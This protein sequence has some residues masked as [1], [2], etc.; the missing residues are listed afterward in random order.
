MGNSA[1]NLSGT[2]AQTLVV[3]EGILY[4]VTSITFDSLGEKGIARS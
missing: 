3:R 1:D 2:R 4:A